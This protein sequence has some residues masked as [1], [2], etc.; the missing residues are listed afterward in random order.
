MNLGSGLDAL[1]AVDDV[2]DLERPTIRRRLVV[3]FDVRSEREDEFGLGGTP[4]SPRGPAQHHSSW[5]WHGSASSRT[6]RMSRYP[7]PEECAELTHEGSFHSSSIRAATPRAVI[8]GRGLRSSRRFRG[9]SERQRAQRPRSHSGCSG[10]ETAAAQYSRA[11]HATPILFVHGYGSQPLSPTPWSAL[12]S[13]TSPL[14]IA[15]Q[16]GALGGSCW[17][18]RRVCGD[19][20]D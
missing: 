20:H 13:T 18:I 2:V 8:R 1:V 10:Q 14:G 5:D 3:P 17:S 16:R 12:G 4:I 19:V 7:S 6:A 15:Q 9:A 11:R